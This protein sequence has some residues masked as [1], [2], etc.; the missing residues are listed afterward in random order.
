MGARPPRNLQRQERVQA[1]TQRKK[2]HFYVCHEQGTGR[3]QSRLGHGMGVP[4]P[5]KGTSTG[6]E[7]DDKLFS[8]YG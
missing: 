4:W 5:P 1:G 2:S 8:Y 3:H 7:S 6:L